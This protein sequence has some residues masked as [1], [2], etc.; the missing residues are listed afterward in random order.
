MIIN[1]QRTNLKMTFKG[2]GKI[3]RDASGGIQHVQQP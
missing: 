2:A 1:C 3:S